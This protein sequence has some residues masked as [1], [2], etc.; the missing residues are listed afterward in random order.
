MRPMRVTEG[1]AMPH[2]IARSFSARRATAR[3][4]LVANADPGTTKLCRDE[5]KRQGLTVDTV[6]T[7]VAALEVA[8]KR[9]P[10]V[11]FIDLQLRD[12]SGHDVIAWLQSIPA[13]KAVPIIA[14]S[15]VGED[16]PRLRLAGA[17]TL[18]TKPL[19]AAMVADALHGAVPG[20]C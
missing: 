17:R 20:T 5:L 1:D 13:L 11:I 9:R 18:L 12:A 14:L 3:H 4:A 2:A 16:L 8:R 10:D 19:S 15:A 6:D 7:G